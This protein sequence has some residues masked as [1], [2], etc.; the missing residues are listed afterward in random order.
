MNKGKMSKVDSWSTSQFF[1]ILYQVCENVFLAFVALHDR[2]WAAMEHNTDY[3][4]L[5]TDGL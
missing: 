2:C 5:Q 3:F 1:P 4:S